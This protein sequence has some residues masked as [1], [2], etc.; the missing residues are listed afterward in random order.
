M[1][2]YNTLAIKHEVVMIRALNVIVNYIKGKEGII[3]SGHNIVRFGKSLIISTTLAQSTSKLLYFYYS[4]L[5]MNMEIIY[6]KSNMFGFM[7]WNSLRV[8]PRPKLKFIG[9]TKFMKGK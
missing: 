4:S 2:T 6:F 1:P 9:R 3:K 5:A 7:S 8:N